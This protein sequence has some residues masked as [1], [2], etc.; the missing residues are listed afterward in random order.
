MGTLNLSLNLTRRIIIKENEDLES[1]SI[2]HK[3]TT[4]KVKNFGNENI[5]KQKYVN[6]SNALFN[7]FKHKN[8]NRKLRQ[9]EYKN[10]ISVTFLHDEEIDSFIMKITINDSNFIL[11]SNLENQ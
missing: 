10:V 1:L 8:K 11:N 9:L 4:K 6:K 2:L 5:S 7:E 3:P